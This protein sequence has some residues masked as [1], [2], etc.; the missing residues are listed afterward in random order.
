M[1]PGPDHDQ[2]GI[3]SLMKRSIL[4]SMM[5]AV[6]QKKQEKG[7]T[8]D[9]K[10]IAKMDVGMRVNAMAQAVG[11]SPGPGM[12]RRLDIRNREWRD[13]ERG[14]RRGD[15][16]WGK[17][18]R[19]EQ[20][21]EWMAEEKPEQRK[22]KH[23]IQDIEQ[24]KAQM[25]AQTKGLQ[26]DVSGGDSNHT[27][28]ASG[29]MVSKTKVDTPLTFDKGVDSF[30]NFF[31]KPVSNASRP[32][33]YKL[34]EFVQ[35]EAPRQSIPKSSRFTGFF[36]PQ[37]TSIPIAHEAEGIMGRDADEMP[38]AEESAIHAYNAV[39]DEA[40]NDDKA[41]FERM[42]QML[43]NPRPSEVEQGTRAPMAKGPTEQETLHPSQSPT[44]HSPRSQK[45]HGLE[46]LLGAQ[47]SR[48]FSP[49]N[50]DT[51]FL[52]NLLRKD[53]GWQQSFPGLTKATGNSAPGIL[54]H[55]NVVAQM[56][57]Q[58]LSDESG[59]GHFFED[60]LPESTRPVDKLN[61]T[62]STSRNQMGTALLDDQDESN[63]MRPPFPLG[64]SNLPPGLHLP[65]GFD[66]PAAPAYPGLMPPGQGQRGPMGP[67][68]GFPTPSRNPN[69]G[70]FPPGL[71]PGMANLNLGPDRGPAFNIGPGGSGGLFMGGPPPF[72]PHGNPSFP[73][74]GG[75]NTPFSSGPGGRPPMDMFNDFRGNGGRGGPAA[76]PSGQFTR[77]E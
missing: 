23:T 34:H 24:W 5:T 13:S 48:E 43:R 19:N 67:P 56:Q 40:P 45:T 9:G 41:G 72:P 20:D 37:T 35:Q 7:V 33:D 66:H 27:R 50:P 46:N 26:E 53:E 58:R 22:E 28:S 4:E 69:P 76:P 60:S 63:H 70:H 15:K 38:T 21:P 39:L 57:S 18:T 68:P 64:I 59:Q 47:S 62:T 75:G 61:P 32:N 11:Q 3:S 6:V 12:K 42:L 2:H 16:D 29:S 54:P 8:V 73:V 31:D 44:I 10:R 77:P 71:G 55:P 36:G 14:L 51:E 49:V 25:R 17:N 30:F 65:P 74:M 1:S 52:L